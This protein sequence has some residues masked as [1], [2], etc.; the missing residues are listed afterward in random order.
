MDIAQDFIVSTI[1]EGS[2]QRTSVLQILEGDRSVPSEPKV[3]EQEILGE[4][5]SG[6]TTE[7][8]GERILDGTEIVELKN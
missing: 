8:E 3:D 1:L 7:V 4:Y 2:A 5:R 6:G